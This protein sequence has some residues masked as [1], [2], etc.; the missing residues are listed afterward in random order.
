MPAPDLKTLIRAQ[1]ALITPPLTPELRMRGATPETP[2]WRAGDA[3][4]AALALDPPFWAFPW[5][6]GQAMARFILDAP[7][8][9]EGASILVVAAGAG[10]EAIA[11]ARAGARRVVANDVDPAAC[12]AAEINAE[13]NGV[14]LETDPADLT[15]SA[16]APPDGM[17]SADVILVADAL[18]DSAPSAALLRLA[19]R[20][21]REGATVLIADAGRGAGPL[22]GV[23]ELT[24]LRVPT[25][26][27]PGAAGAMDALTWEDG[28]SRDVAIY[29]MDRA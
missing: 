18:Y 14:R 2:L 13:I 21:A 9:V 12:A 26:L 19:E 29:E 1:T 20:A 17:G 11:A 3:E 24:R 23:T 6:G 27:F 4:L 16:A 15:L 10:L 25:T 5:A 28:P 8:R 22:D 7:E